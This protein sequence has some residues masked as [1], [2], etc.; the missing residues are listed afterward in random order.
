MFSLRSFSTNLLHRKSRGFLLD[1][2]IT[3]WETAGF[4]SLGYFEFL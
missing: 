1:R 4:K 2:P 3:I